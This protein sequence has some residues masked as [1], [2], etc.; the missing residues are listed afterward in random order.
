M[1]AIRSTRL[2]SCG[3]C[4]QIWIPGT[5]DE[6][7]LNSLRVSDGPL[8]FMTQ[9][10][11]CASPPYI[12]SRMQAFALLPV[13]VAVEAAAAR[14]ASKPGKVKPSPLSV[15]RRRLSRRVIRYRVDGECHSNFCGIDLPRRSSRDSVGKALVLATNAL[16]I[17]DSKRFHNTPGQNV[18]TP[19]CGGNR[20]RA[21]PS[22]SDSA[23]SQLKAFIE[24]D[25]RI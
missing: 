1:I 11:W 24:Q 22:R 2:E 6:I 4:S 21:I 10:S 7:G 8:G 14:L 9:V 16:C 18:A 12:N 25:S 19:K 17:S 23:N 15:P 3:M 20:H 13:L 5:L